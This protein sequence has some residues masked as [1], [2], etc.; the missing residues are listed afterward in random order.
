VTAEVSFM[1]KRQSV[2]TLE[3]LLFSDVT[4]AI[5]FLISKKRNIDITVRNTGNKGAVAKQ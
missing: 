3:L 5:L 2:K 1:W 4:N